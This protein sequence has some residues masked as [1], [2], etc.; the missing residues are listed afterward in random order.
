PFRS[1]SRFLA[2]VSNFLGVMFVAGS[3]LGAVD[4]VSPDVIYQLRKRVPELRRQ[5]SV[6]ET[7]LAAQPF[8]ADIERIKSL[9]LAVPPVGASFPSGTF[10]R[11]AE[12]S[13]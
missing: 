11:A 8:T 2:L 4:A 5:S 12:L 6:I 7:V 10:A 3:A 13:L 9:L 1:S